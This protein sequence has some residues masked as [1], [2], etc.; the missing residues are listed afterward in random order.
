V[1]GNALGNQECLLQV[2]RLNVDLELNLQKL[3]DVELVLHALGFEPGHSDGV[4]AV[5]IALLGKQDGDNGDLGS[6][7]ETDVRMATPVTRFC[8]STEAL[9]LGC[10]LLGTF[11]LLP[12]GRVLVVDCPRLAL[13]IL[14]RGRCLS[15]LGSCCSS[16]SKLVW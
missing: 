5:F 7:P 13:S 14:A 9:G 8:C 10:C 15:S 4:F 6:Q 2:S 11:S 16:T 3:S 12:L 1:V